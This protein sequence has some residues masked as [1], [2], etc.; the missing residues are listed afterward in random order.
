MKVPALQN[1]RLLF[2]YFDALIL[3]FI[4][5]PKKEFGKKKKVLIVYTYALG[6]SVIFYGVI[7]YIKKAFPGEKYDLYITCNSP[8]KELFETAFDNVIA[9]PYSKASTSPKVRM[10]FLKRIRE[11]YFDIAI[12]PI[13]CEEC[14]PNVF[15]MN[16]VCANEKIG[17]LSAQDKK[18][19]CPGWLRKKAYTNVHYFKEKNVHKTKYYA[20]VASV[21]ANEQVEPQ[22]SSLPSKTTDFDLPERYIII[23]PSASIPV[24]R[25]PTEH[26]VNITANI[27]KLAQEPIVCCG[28]NSD[29]EV[30]DEYINS[31][32]ADIPVFNIAGKTSV[33]QLID[34]IKN[35]DLVI[36][37]DTSI[38]HIAVMTQ[39]PTCVV[40]GC[41]VYDEF[42]NYIDN[43]KDSDIEKNLKILARK[44][45][46]MNCNNS[47]KYKF[48]KTYPCVEEI[49]E[50]E[51]VEAIEE[52]L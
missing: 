12:D 27:Y 38:F 20:N 39:R 44:L 46:C 21:I 37:N 33:L 23:N 42:L 51:V 17:F 4:K 35:A 9:I 36:T 1:I 48:D 10:E 34:V 13:G 45:E 52:L 28:T 30:I 24:K 11:T 16:A 8:Y 32:T 47:C 29:A 49:T 5:K 2:Y 50:Q 18:Y 40:S 15:A 26:F 3:L 7:P 19:Q 14:G 6:D 25:W 31:L 43:V 41:Y 22:L